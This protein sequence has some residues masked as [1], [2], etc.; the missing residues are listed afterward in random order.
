M[1]CRQGNG[2]KALL[3]A[4]LL[5]H[6]T[7]QRYQGL[8]Q[9]TAHIVFQ[10][11][12]R[13]YFSWTLAFS[14]SPKMKNYSNIQSVWNVLPL[15]SLDT[16]VICHCSFKIKMA[17]VETLTVLHRQFPNWHLLSEELPGGPITAACIL[18][19]FLLRLPLHK[20]TLCTSM[21]TLYVCLCE[22]CVFSP[23]FQWSYTDTMVFKWDHF[24]LFFPHRVWLFVPPLRANL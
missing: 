12:H 14:P 15:A 13:L 11:L 21:Y 5:R 10:W 9:I 20:E 18:S 23:L 22:G 7:Y 16:E 24:S 4:Q 19:L 2:F 8:A 17:Q 6:T 3:T 1:A